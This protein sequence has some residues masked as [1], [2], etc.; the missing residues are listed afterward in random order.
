MGHDQLTDYRLKAIERGIT[1]LQGTNERQTEILGRIET[2]LAVGRLTFKQH[3]DE[4]TDLKSHKNKAITG[5][6]VGLLSALGTVLSWIIPH[7]K[8]P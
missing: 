6:I 7:G 1:V 3:G 8:G 4:I 5:L 2:D